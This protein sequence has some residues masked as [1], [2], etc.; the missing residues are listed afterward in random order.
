MVK[1]NSLMLMLMFPAFFMGMGII[2]RGWSGGSLLGERYIMKSFFW[3]GSRPIVR[4]GFTFCSRGGTSL[5]L[6]MTST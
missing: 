2:L 4:I 5:I 1:L 6:L 3:G